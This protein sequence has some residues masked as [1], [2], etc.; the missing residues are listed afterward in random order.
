MNK[1]SSKHPQKWKKKES[2]KKGIRLTERGMRVIFK[3]SKSGKKS[4]EYS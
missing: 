2:I 4:H 3:S 1:L